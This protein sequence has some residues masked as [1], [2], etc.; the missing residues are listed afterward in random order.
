[1]GHQPPHSRPARLLKTHYLLILF[2]LQATFSLLT[3]TKGLSRQSL[4]LV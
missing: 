3:T 4:V 1:M 2:N